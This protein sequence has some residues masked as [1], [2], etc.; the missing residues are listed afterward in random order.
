MDDLSPAKRRLLEQWLQE[1][2]SARKARAIPRA[3]SESDGTWPVSFQQ[4]DLFLRQWIEPEFTGFNNP[5]ALRLR[6]PLQY[7]A[8]KRGLAALVERH[9][10]LRTVYRWHDGQVRQQVMP[11]AAPDLPLHVLKA[12][13]L[14]EAERQSRALALEFIRHPFDLSSEFSL[15]AVLY[16][17]AEHDHLLLI[18]VHHIASDLTSHQHLLNGLACGYRDAISGAMPPESLPI[19]YSDY[20]VW[21]RRTYADD[22]LRLRNFWS[23]ALEGAPMLLPLAANSPSAPV[24][25]SN[26]IL[27]HWQVSARELHAIDSVASVLRSSRFMVILSVVAQLLHQITHQQ[28]LLLGV[29]VNHR[30]Q[31][32]LEPLIGDLVDL[33]PLRLR[34]EADSEDVAAVI[35]STR[36]TLLEALDHRNMPFSELLR[37]LRPQ[38]QEGRLPLIQAAVT[39]SEQQIISPEWPGLTVEAI[40]I[41]RDH[42]ALDLHWTFQAVGDDLA[43]SLECA[44]HRLGGN[45]MA[46]LPTQFKDLLAQVTRLS[47]SPDGIRQPL[48]RRRPQDHAGSDFVALLQDLPSLDLPDDAAL[49]GKVKSND[50][51]S[52]LSIPLQPSVVCQFEALCQKSDASLEMG[53]IALLAALLQRYSRQD[54]F[55]LGVTVSTPQV[56][57]QLSLDS[58]APGAV[59]TLGIP[60]HWRDTLSFTDL[61]REVRRERLAATGLQRDPSASCPDRNARQRNANRN[62]L[63]QVMI[64][65]DA[66]LASL[67]PPEEAGRAEQFFRFERINSGLRLSLSYNPRRFLPARMQRAANHL[68]ALLY[69]V[70]AHP[71][72][73]INQLPL[74]T[75]AEFRQLDAWNQGPELSVPPLCLH[76]LFEHQVARN[77]KAIALVFQGQQ[78]SYAELNCRANQL[79]HALISR[80][81]GRAH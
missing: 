35:L 23:K 74:L 53:L 6:G 20:A 16:R 34:F 45:T 10:I 54:T 28:D 46:D 36:D 50:D 65:V 81:V 14:L 70:L 24:R 37:E 29:T 18:V 5:K 11:M 3:A 13:D 1:N 66:G 69:G 76:Q 31:P 56:A 9:A 42:M 43:C 72:E 25:Q 57:D 30:S 40:E 71:L 21:Q 39:Y 62:P 47:H 52:S 12:P 17:L 32:E 78:L 27:H 2:A 77:P 38:R 68:Q 19:Q 15:R 33:L 44:A 51:P 60:I 80:G 79:S 26:V 61:L 7:N 41:A 22:R 48:R 63:A 8:L 58:V 4:E 55:S 73:P 67:E 75:T 59:R 49:L 64:G